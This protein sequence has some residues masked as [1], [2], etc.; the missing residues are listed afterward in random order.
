MCTC[1]YVVKHNSDISAID[2]TGATGELI[3]CPGCVYVEAN[4]GCDIHC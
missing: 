2:K 3:V 4:V 1:V